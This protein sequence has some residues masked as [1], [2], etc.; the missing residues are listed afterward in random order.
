MRVALGLSV[1]ACLISLASAR[2][3]AQSETTIRVDCA[4]APG[5]DGS[6]RTPVDTITAGV[7]IANS[8]AGTRRVIVDVAKGVCDRET[9]PIRIDVPLHLKGATDTLVTASGAQTFFSIRADDVEISH[10]GIDGHYLVGPDA[11]VDDSLIPI[12]VLVSQRRGFLLHHLRIERVGQAVR[13]EGSSG[14]IANN[15][16]AGGR[17]VFLSG[18][19]AGTASV[20]VASNRIV[21]RVNGITAA[22]AG[23]TSAALRAVIEDNEIETS[24]TNSGPTN[25]AAVRLNPVLGTPNIEGQLDVVV[26]GNVIRGGKYGIMVHAGQPTPQAGAAYTGSVEGR[27]RRNVIEASVLHPALLTFTNA[28]ATVLPCELNPLSTSTS[29]P[30]LPNP[31]VFAEYLTN[32]RYNLRHSGE[33]DDAL[34]DYPD[35]HPIDGYALRNTLTI[36]H[37]LMNYETFVVVPGP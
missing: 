23:Q 8:Q 29:C 14:I 19:H 28:R 37:R 34:I 30:S 12:G 7:T 15:D 21:F 22:A 13:S 2:P 35:F 3:T 11:Q 17:G 1:V 33:L 5:G 27:F 31:I 18:N 26:E 20:T 10:L 32:S 4:A 6:R 16:F 25:P 24:F 36:D 9:L